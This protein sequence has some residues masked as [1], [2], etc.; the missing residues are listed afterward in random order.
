MFYLLNLCINKERKMN[1]ILARKVNSIPDTKEKEK[2]SIQHDQIISTHF[3][4]VK[5]KERNNNN[6]NIHFYWV[7]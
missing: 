1:K 6:N 4:F 2:T 7:H 3:M 5:G